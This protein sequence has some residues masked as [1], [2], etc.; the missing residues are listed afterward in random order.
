MTQPGSRHLEV[1]NCSLLQN[2]GTCK[3]S[4]L[5]EDPANTSGVYVGGF[6]THPVGNDEI[7]SPRGFPRLA[8]PDVAGKC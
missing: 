1:C 3:T 8:G 2:T 7:L 5:D 4:L 6:D